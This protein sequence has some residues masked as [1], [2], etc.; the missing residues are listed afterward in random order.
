MEKRYVLA[1]VF[2][3]LAVHTYLPIPYAILGLTLTSFLYHRNLKGVILVA[4]LSTIFFAPSIYYIFSS[5]N[6]NFHLHYSCS[7]CIITLPSLEMVKPFFRGETGSLYDLYKI[8]GYVLISLI[9]LP[10]KLPDI[11]GTILSNLREA[12]SVSDIMSRYGFLAHSINSKYKNLTDLGITVNL[13]VLVLGIFYIRRRFEVVAY[14]L[15]LIFYVLFSSH[16]ALLPKMIYVLLPIYLL[17][18]VRVI[19]EFVLR[20]QRIL[21]LIFL[22]SSVLRLAEFIDIMGKI[23]PSN[24][25]SKNREVVDFFKYKDVKDED[26]LLYCWPPAFKIF[27]NGKLDPMFFLPALDSLDPLLRKKTIEFIVNKSNFRY[28]VFYVGF[29]DYLKEILEEDRENLK[30]VFNNQAF[31]IL[32]I[33]R[34]SKK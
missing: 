23:N 6:Q 12:F 32:E 14:F 17:I 22:V 21:F 16:L 8:L 4:L 26:I 29:I 13:L 18:S 24:S 2:G 10:F 15:S 34:N 9:F 7:N 20:K 33:K 1:G 31:V 5:L 28:V 11:L 3:G 27:S 25:W 19:N 30:I